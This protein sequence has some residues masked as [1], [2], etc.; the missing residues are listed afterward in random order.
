MSDE[1]TKTKPKPTAKDAP[2]EGLSANELLDWIHE[3]SVQRATAVLDAQEA[4]PDED[5]DMNLVTELVAWMEGAEL[6][7]T[8]EVQTGIA[9]G[10][11]HPAT[12]AREQE[13]YEAEAIAYRQATGEEP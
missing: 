7:T 3:G 11:K 4:L 8:L 12:S 2:P 1:T 9:D 6:A 13:M 5:R 10:P